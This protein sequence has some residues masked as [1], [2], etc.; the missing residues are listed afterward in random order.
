LNKKNNKKE[1]V[2]GFLKNNVFY[3]F[4]MVMLFI[5]TFID[6]ITAG[7]GDLNYEANLLYMYSGSFLLT[8]SLKIIIMALLG[9]YIYYIKN[10]PKL[11]KT[12]YLASTLLVY[13]I[14]LQ[15]L[16]AGT[17]IYVQNEIKDHPTQISAPSFEEKQDY[18]VK[19][20]VN[21]FF[22]PLVF[23]FVGFYVF[24]KLYL[25]NLC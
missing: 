16:G 1:G 13:A 23:S 12:K 17:N 21:L 18:Y 24:E 19:T 15:F 3:S 7:M 6:I 2:L 10:K 11:F 5:S 25:K 20:N 14:V 4:L 8:I 22:I 9:F